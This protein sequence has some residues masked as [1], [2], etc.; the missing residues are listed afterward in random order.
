MSED[1]YT[2][3]PRRANNGGCWLTAIITLFIVMMM[4]IVAL[5]LP[6][7]NVYDRLFG[8]QYANLVNAG[9]ALVSDDGQFSVVL[10]SDMGEDSFGLRFEQVGLRPY[11]N[12]NI[13]D[14]NWVLPARNQI[15]YYLALQSDVY[16]LK[17]DGT[18]PD[19][20]VLSLNIPTT[21]ATEDV[22]DLYGY[23]AERQRWE[24]IAG[25]QVGGRIEAT[26]DEIPEQI[27]LFQATPT[28]PIVLASYNVNQLLTSDVAELATI[29]SPAGLQPTI[30]G[31]VTGSL[32]PGFDLTSGYLV[33]PVIRDFAD[34]RALDT[35]TVE[36]IISNTTLRREHVREITLLTSGGGYDGIMIDYRGLAET[37]RDNF[38]LFI[39]ELGESLNQANLLL[40]VVVP[41]AE[42]VEGVW[43]TGG[44]DWRAIGRSA[45]YVQINMGLNPQT[46]KAGENELVDAMLRY[47]K[48]EISRYKILMGLTAQSIRQIGG[49]YIEIGYDESLAGLGNVQVEASNVSET[50]SI[51]P[52][53]EVR[54]YLDGL[55]AEAG[56]DTAINAPFLVYKNDDGSDAAQVWL[57]TGDALRWRMDRTLPVMVAGVAFNDLMEGD[58]A[59]DIFDAIANYKA[60][61]PSDPAPTD[62]ALRWR[63]EGSEGLVDEI[64]TGINEDISVTLT[65][66]DGNYAFNV[67]VVGIGEQPVES[68][69]Q[70]AAVALF[71][72]TPTPTP[73]PT[74]T[75]TPTPTVTPTPVPIVPT[76]PPPAETGGGGG[77]APSGGG[78]G[79]SAPVAGSIQVGNFEYGGHVTSTGNARASAA[80]QRA[81]MTWKK[82]QIRYFP[83]ASVSDAAGAINGARSTGFKI[84]IGTV[85]NPQDLAAGGN[86]YV[87]AYAN[88]LGEIAALGPD[89]IEVWN[90][91]NIDRE[92]PRGQISG[93]AYA[94]MLRQGYQAIKARNA[95]VIVISAAPAPTGAEAAFPGQ[96]V[97]DDRWL[98]D[99]VSAGGLNYMDCLGAHY[100]EGIIPPS[101][102]SGDPRDGY[103]TRYF[104]G[105]L[106]TYWNIVGGQKPIC[107][108]ELGYLSSE[109]YPPLPSFFAWASNVTVQQQAA[110]LAE[111]AALSSQSG[112]VRMMI[113]WNVDFTLYS[114]DPQ[115]GYAMIRPDGSCP[116]CDALAAAR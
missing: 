33:M 41:A 96:V 112:K 94:E 3:P 99:V 72:P 25:A 63:I 106:N 34:P 92:W 1:V 32:A 98:R 17:S 86:A 95:S 83:G 69:R 15:P 44:Y 52:G 115:G 71:R 87:Q 46:F 20:V 54:A 49:N 103:Y 100:N 19:S 11:A 56:I 51:E 77:G 65:A 29:V 111:A 70:G 84:L 85:G 27:A 102:N 60:Q 9:D 78:F 109:G 23:F 97:N 30:N 22:L 93:Q 37:Q 89:G 110:W 74:A 53:S 61:I 50:G 2:A 5:F 59:D 90:E 7:L 58:L 43:Q 64:T 62:L 48:N 107:F 88:W 21:A 113:V 28:Q 68:V 6:P 45:D 16:H 75:P 57:T 12:G 18:E 66:P 73:L 101:Q 79:A 47:A 10:A 108:T 31:K 14:A 116:A 13:G 104:N 105:I 67:A 24:F 42:N 39:S 76:N 8:E 55:E 114:S 38:S 36:S 80:M 40:G 4:V 26:L 82:V 81:G 91:P 35:A